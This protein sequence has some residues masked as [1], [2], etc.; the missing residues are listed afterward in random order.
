MENW[1][2]KQLGE[3]TPTDQRDCRKYEIMLSTK[4]EGKKEE[5]GDARSNDACLHKY[6]L[7]MRWPCPPGGG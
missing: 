6:P 3:V 2:K 4:S 7:H 1:E 5:G